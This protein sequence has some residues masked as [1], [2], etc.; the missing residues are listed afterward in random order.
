MIGKSGSVGARAAPRA[1]EWGARR[2]ALLELQLLLCTLHPDILDLPY[3]QTLSS[4]WFFWCRF[5]RF[6]LI[7]ICYL[8]ERRI[9][10]HFG[11]NLGQYLL[12]ENGVVPNI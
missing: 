10:V 11:N 12:S 2:R 6:G 7:S 3:N 4:V 5:V 1:A 8:K 9:F